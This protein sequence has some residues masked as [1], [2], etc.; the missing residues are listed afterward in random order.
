M[1]DYR[2]PSASDDEKINWKKLR[3]SSRN[4]IQGIPVWRQQTLKPRLQAE[5]T[6]SMRQTRQLIAAGNS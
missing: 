2:A 4:E 1:P 5:P 6:A 3:L